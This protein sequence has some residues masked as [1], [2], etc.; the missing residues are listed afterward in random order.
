[1]GKSYKQKTHERGIRRPKV[2]KGHSSSLVPGDAGG[3]NEAVYMK[4]TKIKHIR[5][6]EP[7]HFARGGCLAVSGVILVSQQ[8]VLL[9]CG[10]GRPGM[11]L[12][13][14][15]AQANTPTE[16]YPAPCVPVVGTGSPRHGGGTEGSQACSVCKWGWRPAEASLRP[17]R[18]DK[19]VH[20][21]WPR[22][23]ILRFIL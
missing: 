22:N 11:G 7:G 4:L 2:L 19:A 20:R 12:N 1:M 13:V 21:L 3:D 10:R 9:G 15:S 14:C 23:S 6:L 18:T 16:G 17:P 5:V 8:G